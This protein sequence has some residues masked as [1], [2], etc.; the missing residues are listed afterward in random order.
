MPQAFAPFELIEPTPNTVWFADAQ[1]VIQAGP[2]NRASPANRLGLG[3]PGLFVVFTFEMT[4]REKNRG[5]G[6]STRGFG[7]PE[8]INLLHAHWNPPFNAGRY[9]F[10]SVATRP[11]SNFATALTCTLP[12]R[13]TACTLSVTKPAVS[14]L[15]G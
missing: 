3:F 8:V 14:L 1:R 7:L 2:A 12:R 11:N 6:S 15:G 10:L 4:G 13:L 5:V 9:S